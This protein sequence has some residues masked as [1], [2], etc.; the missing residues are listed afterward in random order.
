MN[1][2]IIY[3]PWDL[4]GI[5]LCIVLAENF[6]VLRNSQVAPVFPEPIT[7]CDH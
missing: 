3:V 1:T 6:T 5:A 2:R 7:A 4:L